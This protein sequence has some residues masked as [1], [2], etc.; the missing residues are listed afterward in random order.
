VD[1][2]NKY[3]EILSSDEKS[4]LVI[5]TVGK[6]VNLSVSVDSWDGILYSPIVITDNRKAEK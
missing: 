6:N 5:N 4:K 3:R 1:F 2:G